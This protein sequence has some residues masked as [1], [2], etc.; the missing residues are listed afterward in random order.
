V[1]GLPAALWLIGLFAAAPALRTGARYDFADRLRDALVLGVAI[2]F[3]LGFVHALYAA[4]C[5]V[6]LAICFAIAWW[7]H[8]SGKPAPVRVANAFVPYVLIAALVAVA[9]PQLMRPLL[10]GDSLSYHLPNAA[11]WVQAHSIWTS[12]TRYWWYPPASE[13]FAAGLYCVATPFAL[14]WSGTGALALLGVRI[15]VWIRA[16]YASPPLLADAFA[17]ATVTAYP[18]AIQGAT[19]QNDV[20]LAAFFLE[21]LWA[22]RNVTVSATAARSLAVTALTKP[23]GWILALI[24]LATG[25]AKRALWFSTAGAIAI[26]IARDA[27][28]WRNAG[29]SPASA[30]YGNVA[31]S[32]ILAHGAPAF[33][34]LARVGAE[35][36]PFGLLALVA[37]LAGPLLRR[38]EPRFAWAACAT[39]LLFLV[40]PFGY[41]TSVAQ[42]ATGA[43]L[44]FA[45]PAIATGSL[46]LAGFARRIP[47]ITLLLIA[48]TI[49]G[50]WRMLA[51]FWNDGGTHVAIAVAVLATVIAA[52]AYAIRRVWPSAL[53]VGMGV[54][55][56]THLAARHPLDYYTD[57]LRV[58][59]TSPGVY[60]WIARTRPAAIGGWGLRLGVVNVLSPATR[61]L[62][63]SDTDACAQAARN[64]LLLVAVAQSD[65]AN[66]ANAQRLRRARECGTVRYDDGIAVVASPAL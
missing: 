44:R 5:W 54:I 42:L 59:N 51:I 15:F 61:T 43:S 1:S 13:L 24:A 12:A 45:A 29:I 22:L 34:Q 11:S 52:F 31:S 26:W 3:S 38:R 19:L 32:T 58:G 10:D 2:A 8:V 9:W 49:Y 23:Q 18:L 66:A 16:A 56:A 21:S 33:A 46:L 14:P 57:A 63:L 40:L 64:D 55:V 48:S 50:I 35:I 7:R 47:T 37:A 36:S 62:D 28:L 30:A 27:L 17:A 41:A 20:W 25:K 53:A 39:A 4:A 65:L 60:R 6:A